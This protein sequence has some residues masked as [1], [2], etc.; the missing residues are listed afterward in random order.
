MPGKKQRRLLKDA[1]N[2]W[3]YMLCPDRTRLRCPAYPKMG[4]ECWKVTGTKC[5]LGRTEQ[6]SHAEKILY[7]RGQCPF[8]RSYLTLAAPE[9]RRA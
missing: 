3:E 7:C 5:D 4:R 9:K 6:T 8:Y 1:P 2:C